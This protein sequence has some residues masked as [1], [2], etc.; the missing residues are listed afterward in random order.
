MG[1]FSIVLKKTA[2]IVTDKEVGVTVIVYLEDMSPFPVRH[3][4]N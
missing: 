3:V 2:T 4:E 1:F